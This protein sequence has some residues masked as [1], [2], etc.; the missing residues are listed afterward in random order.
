MGALLSANKLIISMARTFA[1]LW[2]DIVRMAR[3]LTIEHSGE[4]IGQTLY[5]CSNISIS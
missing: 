4:G 5:K 2:S 1:R 3:R